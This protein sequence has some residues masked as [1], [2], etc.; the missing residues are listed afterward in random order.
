MAVEV[1]ISGVLG[2]GRAN[3]RE[4][5]GWGREGDGEWNSVRVGRSVGSDWEE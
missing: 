2:I 3:V 1:R 4:V 5:T